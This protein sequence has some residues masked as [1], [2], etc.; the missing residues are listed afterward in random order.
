MRRIP[1]VE[2][3][4]SS[5]C[6]LACLT[7]ILNYFGNHITLPEIREEFNINNNGLS[8]KNLRDISNYYQ[9]ETKTVKADISFLAGLS[10]PVILHWNDNHFVVLKKLNR[11]SATIVDPAAGVQKLMIA[12]FLSRFTGYILI[13]HPNTDF[14]K[15]PRR[16]K[17]RFLLQSIVKHKKWIVSVILITLFIQC[18][19]I[20]IPMLIANITNEMVDGNRIEQFGLSIFLLFVFYC[21]FSLTRGYLVSKIQTLVDR[22]MM[23]SFI[24]QL[25]SLSYNFF[26]NRT[27]GD[28]VFRANSNVVI[29]QILSTRL[30]T[31]VIDFLM[32]FIY[33]II[34]LV[35]LWQLALIVMVLGVIQFTIVLSCTVFTKKL[36]DKAVAEQSKTQGYISESVQGILDIKVL[37]GES[38]VYKEW[39]TRFN[40]QLKYT[41]RGNLLNSIQDSFIQGIQIIIP[42][43]TL[44]IGSF[45][46]TTTDLSVGDIIGFNAIAIA[47]IIPITSLG[48]AYNQLLLVDTYIKKIYDV[49]ATKKDKSPMVVNQ[50]DNKNIQGGIQLKAVYFRYDSFGDFALK[51]I[52]M[53][54]M[55]GEKV[56]IVGPSGSGKSTL[57]KLIINLYKPTKG[58][59]IYDAMSGDDNFHKVREHIGTV[60]QE[61]RLFHKTV[62]DNIRLFNQSISMEKVVEAAKLANIHDDIMRLP[63]GYD[64]IISESGINL[65]GG[66]RQRILIARSLVTSPS[67]LVLDEATS[68]LDNSSQNIIESNMNSLNNTVVVIAHRLSTVRNCDQIYVMDLGEIVEHGTHDELLL[69]KGLYHELYNHN[70]QPVMERI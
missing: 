8:F 61:S 65:S 26:Q 48:Q 53:T 14:I 18:F 35:T 55:K 24:K 17:W 59:V 29:R 21:L 50:K 64:T 11:K 25:F 7:M 3:S 57:A 44:W 38:N 41:E 56:G 67:I 69:N 66:Q 13:A 63:I 30:V 36:N 45:Y 34:M 62:T 20:L 12:D 70:N 6:G 10:E 47:F 16:N 37:G 9:L 1:Y 51:N 68:F 28:L 2:Q 49:V 60:L 33:A 23:S 46:V 39:L 31:L 15:S 4:E 52:N 32:L 54:I 40:E 5:E 42:L 22:S 27:V 19:G 58:E 43:I